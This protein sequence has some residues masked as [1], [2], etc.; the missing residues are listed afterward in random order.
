ML[1]FVILAHQEFDSLYHALRAIYHEEDTYCVCVN[2]KNID[3]AIKHLNKFRVLPNFYLIPVPPTSWGEMTEANMIGIDFCL[4]LGNKWESLLMISGVDLPLVDAATLRSDFKKE[5]RHKI[6]CHGGVQPVEF[7]ADVEAQ[8]RLMADPFRED[9]AK[10][11]MIIYNPFPFPIPTY[12]REN[13]IYMNSPNCSRSAWTKN[14]HF[15][16]LLSRQV[17]MSSKNEILT[18]HQ[19]KFSIRALKQIYQQQSFAISSF[20]GMILPRDFCEFLTSDPQSLQYYNLIS[21]CFSIEESFFATMAFTERFVDRVVKQ[22]LVC[23]LP[24]VDARISLNDLKPSSISGKFFARKIPS[25]VETKEEFVNAAYALTGVKTS[26]KIEGIQTDI[27]CRSLDGIL[28]IFK[29]LVSFSDI[30]FRFG[31]LGQDFMTD[32]KFEEDGRLSYSNPETNLIIGDRW[33]WKGAELW[34][35]A[36]GGSEALARFEGFRCA[37][38]NVLLIG[39]WVHHFGFPIVLQTALGPLIPT[40]GSLIKSDDNIAS[41]MCDN[42]LSWEAWF[43]SERIDDMQFSPDGT[44]VTFSEC[45]GNGYWRVVNGA[46]VLFGFDE[47]LISVFDLTPEGGRYIHFAGVSIGKNAPVEPCFVRRTDWRDHLTEMPES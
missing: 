39:N 43:G 42:S 40:A 30:S 7:G 18:D 20:W 9:L 1:A 28:S 23:T 27:S 47:M 16:R 19:S 8:K 41:V 21:R 6:V 35:C 14:S 32:V 37:K 38:G 3:L 22:N 45:G 4:H 12:N 15:I 33:F 25:A 10:G 17:N 44:F 26:A 13:L 11:E 36:D 5:F 31:P 24:L 34:T 46:I 29:E 2:I